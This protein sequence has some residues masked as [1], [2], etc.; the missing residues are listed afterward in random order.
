MTTLRT[1]GLGASFTMDGEPFA[2]VVSFRFKRGE[3]CLGGIASGFVVA[4]VVASGF[5]APCAA[6]C[7]CA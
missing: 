2:F 1:F 4:S 3:S 5:A 7:A 6:T